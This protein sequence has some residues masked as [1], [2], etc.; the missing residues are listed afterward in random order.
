M[1]VESPELWDCSDGHA[2][3]TDLDRSTVTTG[4]SKPRIIS[5]IAI[6]RTVH[7]HAPGLTY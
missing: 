3:H 4:G 2:T 5:F 6:I 7:A 1:D